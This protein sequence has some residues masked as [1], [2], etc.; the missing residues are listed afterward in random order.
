M[1]TQNTNFKTISGK[2]Q[3]YDLFKKT[4]KKVLY[5]VILSL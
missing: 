2:T 4:F 1:M 5:L 3:K